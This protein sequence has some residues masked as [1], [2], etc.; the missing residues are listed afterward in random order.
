MG[1]WEGITK[2]SDSYLSFFSGEA[3]GDFPFWALVWFSKSVSA[4]FSMFILNSG[5]EDEVD[6]C[7]AAAAGPVWLV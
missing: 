2:R 5:S 3:S 6:I 1:E 7:K 4:I